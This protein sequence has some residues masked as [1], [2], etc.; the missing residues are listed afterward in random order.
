ML[1]RHKKSSWIEVPIAVRILLQGMPSI[2]KNPVELSVVS[3]QKDF[4]HTSKSMQTDHILDSIH[5]QDEVSKNKIIKTAQSNKHRCQIQIK[6]LKLAQKSQKPISQ[7]VLNWDPY[8]NN[9]SDKDLF[10]QLVNK[11]SDTKKGVEGSRWNVFFLLFSL[12]NSSILIAQTSSCFPGLSSCFLRP[13]HSFIF[14]PHYSFLF[15][16]WNEKVGYRKKCLWIRLLP[17]CIIKVS[18]IFV[19]SEPLRQEFSKI[20]LNQS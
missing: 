17:K 8:K 2:H 3:Q 15:I 20:N 7:K 18:M 16:T 11:R 4:V 14:G 5:V 13:N 19:T 10:R 1:Q 12:N 6:H 9:D